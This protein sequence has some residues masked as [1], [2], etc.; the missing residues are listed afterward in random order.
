MTVKDYDETVL[1]PRPDFG[2]PPPPSATLAKAVADMKPVRTRSRWAAFLA[3]A[4][5]GLLGPVI[6][7]LGA[8]LRVD[9]PG[10]PL[11]QLGH[12]K[13]RDVGQVPRNQGQAAR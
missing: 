4:L 11:A 8:P 10:L 1:G 2:A 13:R 7:F 3:V 6:A 5:V 9:L 12:R